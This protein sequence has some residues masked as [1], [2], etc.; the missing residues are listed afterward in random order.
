[1]SWRVG[2][3]LVILIVAV[4]T[5][6][7]LIDKFVALDG[8]PRSPVGPPVG[9]M[10]ATIDEAPHAASRYIGHIKDRVIERYGPATRQWEG[11]YGNPPLSYRTRFDP[12][13]T[14][15]YD[16]PTGSLYLSFATE[17]EEWVC[18][19]AHWLAKGATF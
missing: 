19:S 1:M 4:P 5:L 18:F 13:I 17:H 9:E 11:H 10:P 15:V 2:M 3:G 8:P 12:T 7:M 14:L 16:R 6:A